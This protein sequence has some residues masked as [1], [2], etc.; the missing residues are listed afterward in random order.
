MRFLACLLATA[1]LLPATNASPTSMVPSFFASWSESL[2][3]LRWKSDPKTDDTAKYRKRQSDNAF[4]HNPDGS[5]FLWAL[6]DTY[7]GQTFFECVS[8]RRANGIC[9][10]TSLTVGG[11]FS[12]ELIRPSKSRIMFNGDEGR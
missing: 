10:L 1:V 5:Q 3:S 2:N 11:T 9:L 7:Q 8:S 6:Q 12:Q 4:D